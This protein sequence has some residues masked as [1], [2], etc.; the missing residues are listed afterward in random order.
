MWMAL[1]ICPSRFLSGISPLK[2]LASA[3]AAAPSFTSGVAAALSEAP[4]RPEYICSIW[5]IADNTFFP[6]EGGF[7]WGG[8]DAFLDLFE[9]LGWEALCQPAPAR[10]R[11]ARPRDALSLAGPLSGF[12]SNTPCTAL[13]FTNCSPPSDCIRFRCSTLP[14]PRSD[15]RGSSSNMSAT[16][17][18]AGRTRQ[19]IAT[20]PTT[21]SPAAVLP[22]VDTVNRGF[23]KG[24]SEADQ[25]HLD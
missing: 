25:I 20:T 7:P 19:T 14:R 9:S 12:T 24:F 15:P 3:C 23:L 4:C 10:P 5:A 16:G 11:P 1:C 17:R 13:G 2:L 22:I 8:G 6:A 18:A 21:T